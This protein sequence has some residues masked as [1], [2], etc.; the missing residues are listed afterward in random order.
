MEKRNNE[1]KISDIMTVSDEVLVYLIYENNRYVWMK[2]IE[3]GNF[4]NVM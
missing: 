1:E 3:T 2:Q 4:K